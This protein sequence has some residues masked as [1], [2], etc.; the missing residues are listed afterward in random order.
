MTAQPIGPDKPTD[1]LDAH[2][3]LL[4][5]AAY[6][7][8]LARFGISP[9]W[10]FE[11]R[12]AGVELLKARDKWEALVHEQQQIDPDFSLWNKHAHARC[13]NGARWV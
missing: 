9:G 3:A 4:R 11:K 2:R 10:S 12:L 1:I 7:A 13:A 8:M 6:V 5:R